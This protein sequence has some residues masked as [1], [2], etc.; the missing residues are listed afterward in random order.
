M[1]LVWLVLV[2]VLALVKSMLVR[3]VGRSPRL[4]FVR[5]WRRLR[6]RRRRLS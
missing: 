4:R 2:L 5:S 3:P 6:L 1:A